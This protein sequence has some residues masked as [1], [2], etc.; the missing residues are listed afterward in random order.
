[1]ICCSARPAPRS[2][3]ILAEAGPGWVVLGMGVNV[4][5]GVDELPSAQAG[6][7]RMAFP[8]HPVSRDDLLVA[9]VS[10]FA[11]LYRDGW[12]RVTR[13]QRIARRLRAGVQHA[14]SGGGDAHPDRTDLGRA[15]AMDPSGAL[16]V[17][18]ATGA[19]TVSAGDVAPTLTQPA[20]SP[21]S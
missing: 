9:V 16:V 19:V 20:F 8:A 3:G 5:N 14:R 4:D 1:M 21:M 10:A 17:D 15:V 7:L 6:S 2:A 18:T 12:P 11:P 13:R